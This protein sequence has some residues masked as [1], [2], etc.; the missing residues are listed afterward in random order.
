M[1]ASRNTFF[2]SIEQS[3]EFYYELSKLANESFDM[4]TAY[5]KQEYFINMELR[6]ALRSGIGFYHSGLVPSD[7]RLLEKM[8]AKSLIPVLV[9]TSSLAM[10]VN[11]PAH[12]VII[13]NTVQYN[14]GST[15][16]YD[17]SQI[18][19]MIG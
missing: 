3:T 7:R 9:S 8:F 17:S 1:S 19:Q 16:E 2:T 5:D 10:G 4:N 14:H 12:L 13:K 11:L 6:T 18:M 15:T